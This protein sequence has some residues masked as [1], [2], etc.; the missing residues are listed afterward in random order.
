MNSSPPARIPVVDDNRA[1][2]P[3][4]VLLNAVQAM[5]E[6]GTLRVRSG[7]RVLAE[8]PEQDAGRSGNLPR[9]GDEMV[10]IDIEDSGPGL[11]DDQLLAAFDAFYT[12][13]ATG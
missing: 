2:R 11:P 9:R 8:L 12:T 1:T 13:K 4:N 3:N 10:A 5:P 7:L 6:G